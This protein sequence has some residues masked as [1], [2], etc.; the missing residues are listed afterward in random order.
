MTAIFQE[1]AFRAYAALAVGALWCIVCPT[2]A[3]QN[4]LGYESVAEARRSVVKI[5]G[6]ASRTLNGWF[7]V[8]DKAGKT[9]WSFPEQGQI[10]YPS[11]VRRRVI[12]KDGKVF[13]EMRVKCEAE[14]AA[15]KE[16]VERF[17]SL[18]E[19]LRTRMRERNPSK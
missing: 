18:D 4:D 13:V 15:C 9:I 19:K 5:P 12:G 6:A 10:G 14:E 7:V 2:W 1:F 17:A 11:V 16:L 3:A 8:E